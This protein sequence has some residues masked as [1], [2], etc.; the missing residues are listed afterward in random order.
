MTIV[1]GVVRFDINDDDDMRINIDPEEKFPAYY[2]GEENEVNCLQ[3]TQFETT[4][5]H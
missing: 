5:N 2:E 3:D 1:D 4:H